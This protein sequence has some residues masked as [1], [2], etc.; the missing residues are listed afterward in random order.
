MFLRLPH[1]QFSSPRCCF[2]LSSPVFPVFPHL[3]PT[4]EDLDPLL[5]RLRSDIWVLWFCTLL[6]SNVVSCYRIL[7]YPPPPAKGGISINTEDYSCLGE[8]VFL[9]DVIIDF[10]LKYVCLYLP[11]VYLYLLQCLD[12]SK[13]FTGKIRSGAKHCQCLFSID[14]VPPVS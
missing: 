4:M 11:L 14:G 12:R 13:R 3:N 6:Q 7:V 8:D 2:P 9:N 5:P 1:Q 10:Y